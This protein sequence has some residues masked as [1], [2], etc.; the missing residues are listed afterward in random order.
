VTP[1]I[2]T[3]SGLVD[4]F[5]VAPALPAGLS[6]NKTNGAISGK[7]TAATAAANYIV[8]ATN[9]A[10]TAKDTV[11]ITVT[12]ASA[13]GL[14]SGWSNHKFITI[15]TRAAGAAQSLRKFPLLVRLDSANFNT[16][17]SQSAFGGS[18]LRF[19]KTGDVARLPHQIESWDAVAKRA[20]IWVLVDSVR[21][22]NVTNIRMHW[23]K[24][25][26]ADSSNGAAVFEASNGFGAVWHMNE[27]SGNIVDATSNG[28]VGT[29]NGTTATT[30]IIGG[31][32]NFA[33][34]N[35]GNNV[36]TGVQTISVGDPEGLDLGT[37]RVTLEAWVRWDRIRPTTGSTFWR[38]IIM[39]QSGADELHLRVD[40]NTPYN[41]RTGVYISSSDY[42]PLSEQS[43]AAYGDSAKWVH[44]TGVYDS[45]SA[46]GNAW[47]LYRNG[48]LVGSGSEGEPNVT[49]RGTWYIGS[50]SGTNNRRFW[51]GDMDELRISKTHRSAS[52]V[53]LS[54]ETQKAVPTGVSLGD[55]LTPPLALGRVARTTGGS[56]STQMSGQGALFHV[57]TGGAASFRLVVLDMR[58]REVWSQSVAGKGD[59]TV[60]W[61]GMSPSGA[62]AS[63]GVYTVRALLMDARGKV[64]GSLQ[65]SLPLVR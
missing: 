30:G 65:K 14:Y 37:G 1:N 34:T 53:K 52:W 61:N 57:Q 21:G 63:S 48:A 16:G 6:F 12:A 64:T 20:A 2:P 5:T 8:T 15:N 19:T 13:D 45:M 24:A 44:L 7:P 51:A 41:Y 33:G 36:T 4:S 46:S 62:L 43:A 27:A 11:N 60:V 54:Y 10:G 26:V 59:Q 22:D 31:G 49:G 32:R 40:G 56:L 39:R 42:G 38:N 28:V 18:D 35:P 9:G 25:G 47:K 55:T 17:F 3:V 29:N 23:G 50:W 58:G